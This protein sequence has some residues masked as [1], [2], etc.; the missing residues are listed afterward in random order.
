MEH[1]DR[2]ILDEA[3]DRLQ[4]DQDL[5]ERWSASSAN[6]QVPASPVALRFLIAIRLLF[7]AGIL[8]ASGFL[9]WRY[10]YPQFG[11]HFLNTWAM[12]GWVPAGVV[13]LI[14]T[15]AI[16]DMRAALSRL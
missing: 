9:L 11:T 16:R 8:L 5:F 1:F 2:N 13:G 7:V 4:R 3:P 6:K 14:A 15:V 12:V 10:Q